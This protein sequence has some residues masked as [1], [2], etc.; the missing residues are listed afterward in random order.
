MNPRT[1]R[2]IILSSAVA[3]S[4]AAIVAGGLGVRA[5][6][7][8]EQLAAKRAEGLALFA[9]GRH[10]AALAPLAFAARDNGDLEVVLALAE[11]RMKVPEA[12]ARH[13]STAAAYFRSVYARDARNE[14]AMRGLLEAYVALGHL[15]EIQPVLKQLL[16][17]APRDVRA[18]EIE[19][20]V[21]NLTGRFGD[22]ARKAKEL[23]RIDPANARWRAAEL[24]CLERAGADAE[25]R[26]ARVREWRAEGGAA[27]DASLD[28]L[29]SDLLR[30]I[31]RADES[32]TLLRRLAD[33]GLNDRR[34]LE[35][36]I[37]AI[38]SASFETVERDQLVERAIE[39]SRGAL[40]RASDASEI[41][42]ERLLRAGRLDEILRRFADAAPTDPAVFR[43]R[44]AALYLSGR[45][46]EAAAF[47]RANASGEAGRSDV[48]RAAL[49]AAGDEPLRARIEAIAGPQRSCP[50]D[51][52]AAILLA[53]VLL[54]AGEFDEAQSILVHC[55]EESGDSFQPAGVRAVRAS[56]AL[57]R[58]R[59]AFRIAEELLV[60]YGPNGDASVA[61][62]AVEAWAAVLEAS[63]QPATR[64]GVY[65]TDSP[66]A[67]RRFW[68]ALAGP[69]ATQGPASL[70]PV[71][72]DVFLARGDR[73]TAKAILEG[74]LAQ[75]AQTLGGL[76]SGKISRAL[77][78]ASRIDASLQGALL[79]SIDG[80]LSAGKEGAELALVVAERLVAQGENDS[81]LRI[82]DRA[83][84][85]AQG[86]DR[87]R[88][89]RARRPIA[90]PEGIADWLAQELERDPG[91]ETAVFV[92]ARPEPWAATDGALV[93]RA[94]EQ[95][96]A[97]LGADSLRVLVAEAAINM[98]FH[99]E[100]RSRLAAS[101]GA[102]DAAVLRSPDSASVLTTLAALFERQSPPQYERSARLLAR[103]L[104]A[105]PGAVSTYPQLVNALQQIGDFEG[106]EEA[107]EAY[108]AIVGDDL[109]TKRSVAD[110]KA[111][112]G[113]LAEAAQIR[114]QLVGRSKE[115]VDA[116]ALARIRQRMGDV[117]AAQSILEAMRT[118]LATSAAP[119]RIDTTPQALLVEREIALLHARDG[120][121]ADARASLDSAAGAL[122][123]P[124]LDEVRANVELAY[125]D[126]SVALRI[127]EEL[128]RRESNG[129]H[130]LLLARALLRSGDKARAREALTRSLVADPDNTDATTVAAALLVGDPNARAMLERTL[131]AASVQRPDLA[132]SIA[133]LD[134]VTTQDGRVAPTEA[135]LTRAVSL[136]AEHS[137]SPLVW[138][139]AAHL[140]ILADRKDDAYR[141]AQRALSRLPSDAAIGRLATETAIAA[142]RVDDAATAA[143]AWRKM[144]TAESFEVDVARATIELLQRRPAQG[145]ALLKPVA[146]DILTRAGDAAPARVLVACAV[147]SGAWR[148]LVGELPSLPEE[149]RGEVLAAWLEAA[150]VLPASDALAAIDGIAQ[151]AGDA[152]LERGAVA[153]AACIAAWTTLCRDG[154]SD[155]CDRATSA[156]AVFESPIVPKPILT[157]DLASARGDSAEAL[158]MYRAMYAPVL[159]S[160][161][162]DADRA[163]G[164]AAAGA[165]SNARLLEAL[166]K[167]PIAIVAMTNAA[168]TMLRTGSNAAE[169]ASL[170][171]IAV[172]AIPS[173]PEAIDALV[174]ALVA[175]RR[176]ADAISH[177][178]ANPDPVLASVELA[179]IELARNAGGEARRA[180]ARADARI[181]SS[182]ALPRALA[183][184]V[185]RLQRSVAEL[186][187][188]AS[189]G[190][191]GSRQ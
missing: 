40:A 11:C 94:I 35:A 180:L 108:I 162:V 150:Q 81:A 172:A 51:P 5:W 76:G 71:V 61:L 183:E 129:S 160:A 62:L 7:R 82:I 47:A 182:F 75:D 145:Y 116:I 167:S 57:G 118:S 184:R 95:M 26:L 68:I 23:Q 22:A 13:V 99:A 115:V 50:K 133:L 1:K 49:A 151:H 84:A 137:A 25:G 152:S 132:A 125:G 122:A 176:F 88:L 59:D 83:I 98:A 44:Y 123:G 45:I 27:V 173:A 148:E 105:E 168:D 112:Q 78:A 134:S 12:N 144:A 141:I 80:Q 14:R 149:R 64:G 74:A 97:A 185:A 92:L 164:T 60:R 153:G 147:Q 142:G 107:L 93:T 177:A 161:G 24:V 86:A 89:E 91:L 15:P 39:R 79:G 117:S 8:A 30:E 34:Q 38:E 9:E 48:A 104:E 41:E 143:L 189:A 28:L 16:E 19:L 33:A 55:F 110:F 175:E 158:A 17:V 69:D 130:E 4:L 103:A 187:I 121:M 138:R 131:A 29:E 73:E 171:T 6:Y 170:A 114:E 90:N 111:R 169:A 42:G 120:R 139:V 56:V 109:Q 96:R 191:E 179:E 102:L 46:D 87:A 128:V 53:D 2:R 37:G 113:R 31:G 154:M 85:G 135:S 67:L 10:E 165:T 106:A 119:G 181:Q 188:E 54:E 178:N 186:Q 140:H 72:A 124:R 163:L 52:V 32:R 126:L 157:A 58:V 166:R 36:L 20:E 101:I 18:H 100:D 159:A 70:A 43:L 65:G 21:L 155:A 136:T 156:L 3:G 77:K 190:I 127:A 146:R 63:Y 174:R 66:E